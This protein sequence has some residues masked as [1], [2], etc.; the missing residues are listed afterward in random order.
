MT[1]GTV[2]LDTDT[3]SE[4]AK[5]RDLSI[6]GRAQDYLARHLRF[7]FSI[8]TRYELL[9][10]LKAK[11]A[12]RQIATFEEQC[13]RSKVLPLTDEIIVQ[14]AQLY[15]DLRKRG[16]PVNDADL[17]IAATAQVHGLTLTTNNLDHFRRIQNLD[18]GDVAA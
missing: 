16:A 7:Q 6:Q 15:A 8:I 4:I 2:L 18:C 5:G 3:L 1:T 10:G 11:E 9:R 17:L 14:A 13:R 12:H